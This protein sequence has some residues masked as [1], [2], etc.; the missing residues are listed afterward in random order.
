MPFKILDRFLAHG[1]LGTE[2]VKGVHVG[3]VHIHLCRNAG[4]PEVFHVLQRF[5]ITSA[6][7]RFHAA[8]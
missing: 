4:S 6:A 5:G 2:H 1:I 3:G 7:A 8:A